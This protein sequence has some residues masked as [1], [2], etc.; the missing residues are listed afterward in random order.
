MCPRA[1]RASA[2]APVGSTVS[3]MGSETAH[4]SAHTSEARS[5]TP[6]RLQA[7]VD[8]RTWF[9]TIDLGNGV[10]TPGQ[11][12]TPTEVGIMQLP[13]MAGRTVLYT[14]AYHCFYSF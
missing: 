9:H 13:E 11:K 14:G 4:T 1:G 7:E 6:E 3:R 8:S 10:R 2:R 12:D 5:W